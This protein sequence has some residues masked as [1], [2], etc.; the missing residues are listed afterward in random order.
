MLL[1]AGVFAPFWLRVAEDESL[2]RGAPLLTSTNLLFQLFA[3]APALLLRD[4]AYR[5][6][7]A[8]TFGWLRAQWR[9]TSVGIRILLF[10]LF[11]PTG[12]VFVLL[13]YVPAVVLV[14]HLRHRGGHA[15]SGGRG[16]VEG[17]AVVDAPSQPGGADIPPHATAPERPSP[18]PPAS[19][20]PSADPDPPTP[21]PPPRRAW[22]GG[23]ST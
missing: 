12:G 13:L 22:G 7:L 4:P 16:E 17:D 1:Y 11:V 19:P 20:V 15:P 8:G 3:L 2:L 9:A 14:G 5:A 10:V 6:R 21:E 23:A 18:E